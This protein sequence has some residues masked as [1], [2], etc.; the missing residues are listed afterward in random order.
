MSKSHGI[1]L[2]GLADALEEAINK[3]EKEIDAGHITISEKERSTGFVLDEKRK[4]EIER[5]I[6]DV[7]KKGS[8]WK[9]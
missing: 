1:D 5:M 8:S 6:T 9:R 4:A 3:I 2:S 7:H